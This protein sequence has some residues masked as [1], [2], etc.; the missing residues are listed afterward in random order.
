V[1]HLIVKSKVRGIFASISNGDYEPMLASLAPTFRYRFYGDH[2]LGGERHTVPAMR[3]WWERIFRMLPN[4]TF[5]VREIVVAGGPWKTIIATSI[6]I[7]AGLPD[8]GQYDNMFN[9]FIWMRWGK[10]TAV[11]TLEDTQTLVR[12]LDYLAAH[13]YSEAHAVPITDEEAKGQ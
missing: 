11:E 6:R 5:D 10:V 9:Q 2:A 4:P 8:G 13:G 3:M 7:S 12:V 1:Y